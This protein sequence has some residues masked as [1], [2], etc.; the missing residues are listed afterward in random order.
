MLA[1]QVLFAAMATGARA[2][3]HGIPWQEVCA[4][5]FAIGLLTVYVA[6][7]LRGQSLRIVAVRAAW[8]RSAFGTLSAAGTF[9]LYATPHLP[10]GDAATLLATA[11][12]FVSVLGVPVLGE[13]LR[14]GVVAALACGFAGIA[15]VARPSFAIAGHIVALGTSTAAASA[16]A[17][18][19]LRR[20]GSSETT[21]AVVFHF[22]CVGTAAMAILCIPVWR[23]PTASEAVALVVT[24]LSGGLAQIFMTRAYSLDQAARVSILGYSGMILTRAFAVPLFH[25]VP[26]AGQAI[27]SALVVASGVLLALGAWRRPVGGARTAA[28]PE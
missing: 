20:L 3:G 17:F 5:R 27:G 15:L 26:S 12:I 22:A 24:G 19:L 21:E 28:S 9:Y 1:A 7:R 25:E 23:T 18:I 2:S 10:L 8:L 11:P 13:P 14:A 6:A 16:F 4:A